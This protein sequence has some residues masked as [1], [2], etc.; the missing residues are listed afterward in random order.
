MKIIM[1]DSK[2]DKI[3][4][5]S[6]PIGVMY[7]PSKLSGKELYLTGFKWFEADRP[8]NRYDIFIWKKELK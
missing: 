8:K 4:P 3:F 6:K 2:V 5:Y 7:P 1:N